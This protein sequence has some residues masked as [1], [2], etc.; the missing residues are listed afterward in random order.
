MGDAP[1]VRLRSCRAIS[2]RDARG[3]CLGTLSSGYQ[4]LHH[5]LYPTQGTE[6]K[7]AV[8]AALKS[9]NLYNSGVGDKQVRDGRGFTKSS[10]GDPVA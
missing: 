1:S 7:E 5:P 4:Q 2:Q 9:V 6:L 3:C 8:D 10:C